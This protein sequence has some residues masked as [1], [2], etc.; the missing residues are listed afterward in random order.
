M[1]SLL[2]ENRALDMLSRRMDDSDL[3]DGDAWSFEPDAPKEVLAFDATDSVSQ[4]AMAEASAKKAGE[5]IAKIE[6]MQRSG[7]E[8]F[9]RIDSVATV[10]YDRDEA[11]ADH[12]RLVAQLEAI[13]QALR[14]E[15]LEHLPL[16]GATEGGG[17]SKDKAAADAALRA[18]SSNARAC[19]NQ[20]D[21]C[22]SK[23]GPR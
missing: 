17:A 12:A 7:T 16:A 2:R 3:D 5:L 9:D 10:P 4:A 13:E 15:M 8:F 22:V 19:V 14:K 20:L 11:A 6:A 18:V 21:V 23:L 1:S